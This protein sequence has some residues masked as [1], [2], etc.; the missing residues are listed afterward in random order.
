MLNT[1]VATQAP[2]QASLMLQWC[3]VLSYEVTKDYF[4]NLIY[5]FYLV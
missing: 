2:S 1:G 5:L 4:N 3:R